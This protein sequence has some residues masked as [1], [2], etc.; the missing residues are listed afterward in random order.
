M[1]DLHGDVRQGAPQKR[2]PSMCHAGVRATSL[3]RWAYQHT[4]SSLESIVL[5]V[6]GAWLASAAKS[7]SVKSEI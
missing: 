6:H 3:P 5:V 1:P 7:I 2:S 4:T